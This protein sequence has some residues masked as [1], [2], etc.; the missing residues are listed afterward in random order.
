MSHPVKFLEI[1]NTDYIP[2]LSDF[3][4]YEILKDLQERVKNF[5]TKILIKYYGTN[6]NIL[7]VSHKSI[8]NTIEH[9]V[10]NAP[11]M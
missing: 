6:L 1:I 2:V 8:L 3:P 7:V 5:C 10:T 11:G 9:Y 4:F